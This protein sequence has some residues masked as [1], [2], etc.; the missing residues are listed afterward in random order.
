MGSAGIVGDAFTIADPP[1]QGMMGWVDRGA[2]GTNAGLVAANLLMNG[3]PGA[4]EVVM[5]GTGVYLGGDY[6]YHHWRW[7]HDTCNTV[8][9]FVATAATTV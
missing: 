5:I 2:A 8:G 9:H 7:F 1:D 6:A 4:G 3:L